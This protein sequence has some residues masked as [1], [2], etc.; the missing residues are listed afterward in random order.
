MSNWFDNAANAPTVPTSDNGYTVYGS[1]FYAPE[2]GG[3]GIRQEKKTTAVESWEVRGLTEAA[4][5]THAAGI[6]SATVSAEARAAGGGAWT[7]FATA[8]TEGTWEAVV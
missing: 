2:G 1:R 3:I 7:V 4:A 5:K 8:V 6:R